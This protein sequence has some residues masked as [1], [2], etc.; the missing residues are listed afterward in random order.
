MSYLSRRFAPGETIVHEG[1]FHWAQKLWPWI[2]LVMLGILVIGIVIWFTELVRMGT[3][4]MV[5][6]SR[7]V[8]LKRGFWAVHVDEL[9]LNSVE[10]AEIDQGL[11]GRIFGFGKLQLRGRGDTHIN[12]PTMDRP[13]KFRAAI[14]AA[15]MADETRGMQ[16]VEVVDDR[17]LTRRE[18]KRLEREERRTL[19]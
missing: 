9:T 6:T 19:H 2:A 1:R 5:V 15:R 10:G 3:T 13:G 18:R 14:E 17:R 4:R 7:R 8:L 12:F 16:P 11:L